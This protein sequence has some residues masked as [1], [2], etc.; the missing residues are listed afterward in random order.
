MN[1][2]GIRTWTHLGPRCDAVAPFTEASGTAGPASVP[3]D[4]LSFLASWELGLDP[5]SFASLAPLHPARVCLRSPRPLPRAGSSRPLHRLLGLL[6][7]WPLLKLCSLLTFQR[8]LSTLGLPLHAVTQPV[9]SL[10]LRQSHPKSTP[11]A[12]G[13]PAALASS[14]PP[15]GSSVRVRARSFGVFGGC[16]PCSKWGKVGC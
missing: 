11:T 7:L 13:A 9:A 4:H 8:P 14:S 12:S 1:I 15:L 2:A 16:F 6:H 5:D 10:S 3:R